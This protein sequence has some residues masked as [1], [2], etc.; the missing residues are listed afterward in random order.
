VQWEVFRSFCQSKT[1]KKR[2]TR[3]DRVVIVNIISYAQIEGLVAGSLASLQ[4][5]ASEQF[6][7]NCIVAQGESRA[8]PVICSKK[9]GSVSSEALSGGFESAE[10]VPYIYK[11]LGKRTVQRRSVLGKSGGRHYPKR[12]GRNL[13]KE[14]GIGELAGTFKR[15]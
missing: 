2:L 15:V 9:V 11:D 10:A 4:P 1:V 12:R 7:N 6:G 8:V 13:L 3:T 5:G 14:G